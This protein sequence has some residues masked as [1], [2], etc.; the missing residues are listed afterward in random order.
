MP[1]NTE[2]NYRKAEY[3]GACQR[4]LYMDYSSYCTLVLTPK[5]IN[6]LFAS[7]KP[8]GVCDKFERRDELNKD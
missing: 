4:H 5:S 1:V 2:N 7:V 3:C 8:E 6:D